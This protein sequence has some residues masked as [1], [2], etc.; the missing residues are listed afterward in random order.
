MP[1][2]AKNAGRNMTQH[3]VLQLARSRAAATRL[4][5]RNDGAEQE[6]AEDGVD[7]DELGRER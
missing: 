1:V 7:A 4:V 3:D 2:K 5:V 6:R